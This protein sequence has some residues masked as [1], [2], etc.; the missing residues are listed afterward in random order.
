M[1]IAYFDCF[2]GISGDMILGALIDAGL[3]IEE[4][5]VELS[6]TRLPGYEISAKRAEKKSIGGTKFEVTVSGEQ[7]ERNLGDIFEIIE[8]SDLGED[9]KIKGKQVFSSLAKAEAEIHNKPIDHVHFHEIGAID[10]IIDIVGAMIGM[11]MLGIEKAYASRLHVGT[12]FVQCAHGTLPV[13]APATLKLLKDVPIYSTGIE[14][15]LV[16]PTGAAIITTICES[17]GDMPSM[18]VEK[19][20]YGAGSRNLPIPNMLRVLIGDSEIEHEEDRVLLLETNIDDMNPQ[21]YDHI[22]ETLFQKGAK[23]VFLTPIHMKK[24]RPGIILSVISPPDKS[25]GLLE[26]ILKETTTLGVRVSEIKQR[27]TL[28][29]EGKTVNTRFGKVKVKISF[30]AGKVRDITPEYE[31][32]KRIAREH[33]LP[34]KDVYEE[35]KRYALEKTEN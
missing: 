25:D 14:N 21:F 35:A 8:H 7:K 30:I 19:I 6:K 12:G 29:R 10:A 5:K 34:V 28:E 27:E 17:F 24:N 13:P 31:D 18:K 9:I 22:M 4:L 3:D 16:T 26:I 23:D 33:N 11:K 1:K 20:G 15:E 2:S 32:C